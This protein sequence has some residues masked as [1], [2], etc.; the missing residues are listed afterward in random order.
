MRTRYVSWGKDKDD[1]R[2]LMALDLNPDTNEITTYVFPENVVTEDFEKDLINN[3]N[4]KKGEVTM[5]DHKETKSFL[6]ITNPL[7]SEDI[8][9]EKPD[10]ENRL[11]ME[12]NV[13]VLSQQLL[14]NYKEELQALRTRAE[15]LTEFSKD[16]WNDLKEFWSKAQAQIRD[17]S[18]LREHSRELRTETDSVFDYLKQMRKQLNAELVA[19]STVIKEN[20]LA[21]LKVIEDKI[22]KN[23]SHHPIFNDLKDLQRRL[24]TENLVREDRNLIWKEIDTLFKRVKKGKPDVQQKG[25]E[26]HLSRNE[27]R[28]NGLVKAIDR[29]R[30]SIGRDKKELERIKGGDDPA[31][32]GHQLEAALKEFRVLSLEQK[33]ESKSTKLEEMNKTLTMLDQNIANLNEKIALERKEAELKE[34]K[35]KEIQAFH[36]QIQEEQE[37]LKNL[38]DS[39]PSNSELKSTEEE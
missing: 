16:V 20:F 34:E 11:R 37:D 3:W 22:D 32:Q 35:K 14:E 29:M 26:F 8:S 7:V 2:V 12:W 39:N 33:I 6:T 9:W 17:R 23:L 30:S 36:E 21:N 13:L 25:L 18:L 5:P 19:E 15:G 24:K 10:E 1:K 31:N 28:K 4:P 38:A 27:N